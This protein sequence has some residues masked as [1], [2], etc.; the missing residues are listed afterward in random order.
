MSEAERI[1]RQCEV[2]PEK[3]VVHQTDA[4]HLAW[5]RLLAT[6]GQGLPLAERIIASAEAGRR[7]GTLLQAL[8]SGALDQS[9]DIYTGQTWMARAL[10]LAESEGY[11]RIFIDEGA[12]MAALL[13]RMPASAYITR[14]LALFPTHQDSTQPP[15][16]SELFE[17]LSEREAEVL[18]LLADGL[19]YAEAAERLV[20]SLNTVRYHVK[21]IYGKLG[22]EKRVQAIEKARRVGLL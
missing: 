6:K 13:E 10:E 3:P 8:I 14:L 7:N 19:T 22:V 16:E 11:L 20:V 4:L 15:P 18:D 9:Q 17:P 12:P 5:L 1:L 2:S 21:S